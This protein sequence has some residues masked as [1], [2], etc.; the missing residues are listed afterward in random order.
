MKPY[1]NF[2]VIGKQYINRKGKYTV[3]KIEYDGMIIEYSDGVQQKIQDLEMQERI[4]KHVLE[5]R[6]EIS[7]RKSSKSKR[8]VVQD[9]Q[10]TFYLEEVFPIIVEVI[11]DKSRYLCDYVMH[12]D[13]ATG[14]MQHRTGKDL[15]KIA[16]ERRKKD[17]RS[18]QTGVPMPKKHSKFQ[19]QG[20]HHADRR[21]LLRQDVQ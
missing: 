20:T 21:A 7:P 8:S 13:I 17:G 14:L 5:E 16:Q 19:G 12:E 18:Q 2:F 6:E 11:N 4:V 9:E 10:S 15:I 3:L 1:T